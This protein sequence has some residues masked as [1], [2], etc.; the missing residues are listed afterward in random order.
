MMRKGISQ[1]HVMSWC[2]QTLREDLYWCTPRSLKPLPSEPRVIA[3]ISD[4]E[5]WAPSL[6]CRGCF[7]CRRCSD[8]VVL[9]KRVESM[10]F[11]KGTIPPPSPPPPPI[12]ALSFI[13]QRCISSHFYLNSSPV[14]SC[15]WPICQRQVSNILFMTPC[16]DVLSGL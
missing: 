8:C 15:F 4:G 6:L 10:G 13:S 14:F 11:L 9:V 2:V 16:L 3:F 12:P 5:R 7:R 1:I